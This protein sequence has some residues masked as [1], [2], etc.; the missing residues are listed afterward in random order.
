MSHQDEHQDFIPDTATARLLTSSSLDPAVLPLSAATCRPTYELPDSPCGKKHITLPEPQPGGPPPNCQPQTY[1]VAPDPADP[2]KKN[3][4][5]LPEW[6][7]G[8]GDDL[9][10]TFR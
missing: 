3:L 7:T 8:L 6:A 1:I 9:S 4:A 10:A 2:R 5:P